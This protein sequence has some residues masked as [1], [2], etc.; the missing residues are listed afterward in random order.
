MQPGAVRLTHVGA[1]TVLVE[2]GRLRLL[3][4]PVFDPAGG[5][6]SFGWGTGSRKTSD[7]ALRLDAV[8]PIDAVLLS[9]DHHDD[10]LDRSARAWLPQAGQVLTTEAGAHRLRGN[11]VGLAPWASRT[12]SDGDIALRIT[13]TPA[14]HGPA[15]L[16]P[17]IGDVIG[18][19]LEW[20]GPSHGG[21][22]VSGDT[23]WFD[24]IAEVARRFRVSAALLHLGRAGFPITGPLHFTM[25][26]Q[27]GVQVVRA[28]NPRQVI[29]IHYEG[30]SHFREPRQVVESGF[31]HA[32]LAPRLCWLPLGQPIELSL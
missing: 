29:P 10:N 12:L 25:D 1:A 8:G 20:E 28:L 2:I 5:R 31:E 32:G 27:D 16:K 13:A 15:L 26:V 6:Y 4:D 23:I 17:I 18:F 9:H 30:W 22:Y 7:P 14:Q 21:L 11:A 19:M 24:G 3:T